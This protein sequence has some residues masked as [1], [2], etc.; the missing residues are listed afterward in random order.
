MPLPESSQTQLPSLLN[1]RLQLYQVSF[2]FP[3]SISR[4]PPNTQKNPTIPA[5]R[6]SPLM[7]RRSLVA[8][9]TISEH[10]PSPSSCFQLPS[11]ANSPSLHRQSAEQR[12][13]WSQRQAPL[14][15]TNANGRGVHESLSPETLTSPLTHVLRSFSKISPTA[16]FS[17]K[18]TKHIR[19]ARLLVLLQDRNI[20]ASS[21]PHHYPLL[22]NQFPN[23]QRYVATCKLLSG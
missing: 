3:S 8:R 7:R 5:S 1:H 9:V 16:S 17:R 12:V 19:S 11:P 2:R 15:A 23:C 10:V 18:S 6:V 21:A 13:L 4:V 20:D 22:V 14:C